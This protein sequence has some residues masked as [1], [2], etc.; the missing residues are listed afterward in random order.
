M[1]VFFVSIGINTS[2]YIIVYF[3]NLTLKNIKSLEIFFES[4]TYISNFNIIDTSV[5]MRTKHAVT[6]HEIVRNEISENADEASKNA[7]KSLENPDV[8]GL[9]PVN[10]RNLHST[11]T[12]AHQKSYKEA[13]T[14][15]KCTK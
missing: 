2:S 6:R 7:D 14:G 12:M 3:N 8:S 10:H 15:T 13:L 5:G 9:F 1:Q 11:I 4:K